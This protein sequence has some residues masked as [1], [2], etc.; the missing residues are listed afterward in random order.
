MEELVTLERP[1]GNKY[2]AAH[3]KAIRV[4]VTGADG[5]IGSVLTPLLVERGFVVVGARYGLLSGRSALP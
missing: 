3:G 2:A 5:F 4:L 1:S